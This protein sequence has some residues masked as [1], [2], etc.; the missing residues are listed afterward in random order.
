MK[1]LSCSDPLVVCSAEGGGTGE[2]II[3]G[4]GELHVEICLKDLEEDYAKCPLIKKYPVVSYRETV[5]EESDR[6]CMSKSPNKHNRIYV[7]AEMMEE[8]LSKDIESGKTGPKQDPKERA[9]Y[10]SEKYEWGKDYCTNK[11]WSFGPENKGPN[12]LVDATKAVQ[13]M[14]ELKDSCESAW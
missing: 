12:R 1:K 2:Y 7:K 3:A 11:L 9:K 6:M 10:L 4:C 14:G 13:Y 8:D 5:T